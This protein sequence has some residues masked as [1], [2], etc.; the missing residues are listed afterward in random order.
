MV[1]VA[2]AGL[3]IGGDMGRGYWWRP[4]SGRVVVSPGTKGAMVFGATVMV[5]GGTRR[6]ISRGRLLS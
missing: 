2:Y 3:R 5:V 4:E 1:V 6:S